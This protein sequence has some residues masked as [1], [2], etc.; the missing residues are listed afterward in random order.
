MIR[1]DYL[2]ICLGFISS[3]LFTKNNTK[4]NDSTKN[5]ALGESVPGC[6]YINNPT[7]VV[8]SYKQLNESDLYS[9]V[10]YDNGKVTTI[11]NN[12][13]PIGRI[14]AYSEN[15][16]PCRCWILLNES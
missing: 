2:K 11:P 14:I 7:T 6:V 12:S 15:S 4:S 13:R 9:I 16:K 1:R 10:Y 8:E 3:L 5:V